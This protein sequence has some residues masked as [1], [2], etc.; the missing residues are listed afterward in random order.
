MVRSL[1]KLMVLKQDHKLNMKRFVRLAYYEVFKVQPSLLIALAVSALISLFLTLEGS[2]EIT[3]RQL[4]IMYI[5]GVYFPILIALLTNNGLMREREGHTAAFVCSRV[6]L[7]VLWLRRLMLGFFTVAIFMTVLLALMNHLIPGLFPPIFALTLLVP[8]LFF[9]GIMALVSALSCSTT[10]GIIAG[11][12][13][14]LILYFWS[15]SLYTLFGPRYFPFLEWAFFFRYK[16]PIS[17]LPFNKLFYTITCLL[18]L[19]I[20]FCLHQR[21]RQVERF[22]RQ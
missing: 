22:S 7:G 21:N 3:E 4:F 15:P 20:T 6:N 1:S 18:L 10:V 11:L 16:A 17:A 13:V 12:F 5:L 8:A 19:A 9:S 2:F 14:W